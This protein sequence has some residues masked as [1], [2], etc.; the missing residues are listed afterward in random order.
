MYIRFLL[1]K[2]KKKNTIKTI[3]RKGKGQKNNFLLIVG[4]AKKMLKMWLHAD[5]LF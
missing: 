4:T 1:L 2:I 5:G 3:K